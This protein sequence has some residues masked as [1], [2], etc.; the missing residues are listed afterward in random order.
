MTTNALLHEARELLYGAAEPSAT[1]EKAD[2]GMCAQWDVDALALVAKIDAAPA[3]ASSATKMDRQTVMH[4][5]YQSGNDIH[6]FASALLAAAPAPSAPSDAQDA[7]R[8]RWLRENN[9][10]ANVRF[11]F[12][13]GESPY[14]YAEEL[15]M[16]IDHNMN[17]P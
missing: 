9:I 14:V 13:N 16:A 3:E 15:D 6:A 8:Y 5:W 17:K 11:H 1:Q 7:A 2:T 4:L 10:V 12:A